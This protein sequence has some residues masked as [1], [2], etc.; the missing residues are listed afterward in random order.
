MLNVGVGKVDGN[1][2]AGHA[3][4]RLCKDSVSASRGRLLAVFSVEIPEINV[5]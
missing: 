2:Y 4:Q 1:L 3:V 5:P